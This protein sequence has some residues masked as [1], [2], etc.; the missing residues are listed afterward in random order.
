MVRQR[1]RIRFRKEQDLR[2]IGH[3]DLARAWERIFRRAGVALRMSEGF[4]PKPRMVF[5]SAL[6][7]GVIGADEVLDVELADAWSVEQ[8]RP[9]L[10]ARLLD[11]LSIKSLEILPADA[12]RSRVERVTYA[13]TV[14]AERR[15]A[16]AERLHG[17]PLAPLG[18]PLAPQA[19]P[20]RGP[21]G[22][23]EQIELTGDRLQFTARVTPQGT[24]R[25]REL[26]AW[27]GLD[28]LDE[29]GVYLTR[30]TVELAT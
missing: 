17:S 6:A 5:A 27:L 15:A 26:L 7:M 23:V 10:T 14:P 20:R 2:L 25:P 3:H 28:D 8:L 24:T 30:T 19:E 9:A 16:L 21:V 18:G 29:Q 1:V 13:L 12:P 11:G 4:H 22:F